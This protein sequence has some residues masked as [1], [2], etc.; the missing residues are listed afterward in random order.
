M[1]SMPEQKYQIFETGSSWLRDLTI[2][3]MIA[4]PKCGTPMLITS[5]GFRGISPP[6]VCSDCGETLILCV[7]DVQLGLGHGKAKG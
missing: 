6:V 7:R 2:T 3:A 5:K 4:C 1:D